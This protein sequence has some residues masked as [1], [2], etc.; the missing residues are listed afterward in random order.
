ML[1]RHGT[2]VAEQ[3]FIIFMVG[4]EGGYTRLHP[5]LDPAL[6]IHI[7]EY[8]S[9]VHLYTVYTGVPQ[10]STPVH[11]IYRSTIVQYT[12][13]QYIQEYHSTVHQFTVSIYRSTIIY[14]TSIS[15]QHNRSTIAQ[16]ISKK[17]TENLK[18]SQENLG[19]SNENVRFVSNE[20]W[21]SDENLARIMIREV[22]QSLMEASDKM[23]SA[24]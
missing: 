22:L 5:T 8:H 10:Y 17:S 16:Y 20:T 21:V 1:W 9:T 4:C 13:T 18:L 2:K 15:T 11:S 19:F 14:Y 3:G 12:S 23:K 6:Q 7:Q 24:L